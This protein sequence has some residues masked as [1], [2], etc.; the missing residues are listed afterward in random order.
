MV[1][2]EN[3]LCM[4]TNGTAQDIEDSPKFRKL[5]DDIRQEK[6]SL[7]VNLTPTLKGRGK[8]EEEN[9]RW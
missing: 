4:E 8:V 7:L 2:A 5:V 1:E 9:S 3:N 6:V